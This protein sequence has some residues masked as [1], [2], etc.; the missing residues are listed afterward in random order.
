[1]TGERINRHLITT[2]ITAEIAELFSRR[3]YDAAHRYTTIL[4]PPFFRKQEEDFVFPNRTANVSA[5]VVVVQLP[6]LRSRFIKEKVV[7]VQRVI[8]IELKPGTVEFIGT[9]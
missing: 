2:K 9:H 3:G 7:G 8:S 6:F 4:T 5:K 1:M